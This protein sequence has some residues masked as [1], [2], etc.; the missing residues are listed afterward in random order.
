MVRQPNYLRM[1]G[2]EY[3]GDVAEIGESVNYRLPMRTQMKLDARW[4][5]DGVFLGKLDLSDEVIVGTPKG[6]ETVRSTR[7]KDD[8]H[9]W[10][11][12]AI[13]MFVGVPWN[14]RVLVAD[15]P[16]GTRRKYITRAL[17]AKY[18]ATDGC[19]GCAGDSQV[20]VPRCRLRFEKIFESEKSPGEPRAVAPREEEP[21]A[22]SGPAQQAPRGVPPP[23]AAAVGAG[24]ASGARPEPMAIEGQFGPHGDEVVTTPR[25]S[26]RGVVDVIGT[27][28]RRLREGADSSDEAMA[29]RAREV[30]SI[31]ELEVCEESEIEIEWDR[32]TQHGKIYLDMYTG[33]ALDPEL[34]QKGRETK[35]K[36]MLEFGVF[37]EI[38]ESEAVGKKIVNSDWKDSLKRD[39]LVRSRLVAQEV[40]KGDKREDVFAGAPPLSAMRYLLSRAASKG[41]ARS[42][43][44][45]DVSVAF[46]HAKMTEELIV[47]PPAIMR[48]PKKLWRL[49]KTVYGTQVAAKLWQ[50]LIRETTATGGWDPI[51]VLPCVC[52]NADADSMMIYHGDD[53]AVEGHDET[54][55]KCDAVLSNFEVKIAPR[56]GPTGVREAKFLGRTLTWCEEGFGYR[57]ATKHVDKLRKILSMD[58]CKPMDTP[59]S[60]ATGANVRDIEEK[61]SEHDAVIF[62]SAAG[63]LQFIVLDRPEILL[64]DKEIRQAVAA[65]DKLSMM[66]LRRV[67][68]YLTGE[69]E[70]YTAY[71]YQEQPKALDC[72]TDSDWGGAKVTRKSTSAGVIV[73]GSHWLEA[74]SAT[75]QTRALS[76]GEAELYAIVSGASRGLLLKH[77][78]SEVGDDLEL[79]ILSD[80]AAGRGMVQ[81]IGVGKAHHEKKFNIKKV[82]TDANLSDIG[83]KHLART[84]VLALL[85]KIGVFVQSSMGKASVLAC[86]FGHTEGKA[87]EV[88]E[89]GPILF[90]I[91]VALVVMIMSNTGVTVALLRGCGCLRRS[92]PERAVATPD[93]GSMELPAVISS[94]AVEASSSATPTTTTR[95]RSAASSAGVRRGVITQTPL[96]WK[97][98]WASP[99]MARL[100]EGA[101]G[102]FPCELD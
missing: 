10:N 26:P 59:G 74:W 89:E 85:G 23:A 79:N 73:A 42:I 44:T 99:R 39:G 51:W 75:Q 86:L 63:V 65:P 28:S 56:V 7:R 43:A 41:Q 35:V 36:R 45:Y 5:S 91:L 6:I 31:M 50:E 60:K 64:A 38:D 70:C 16:G 57:P 29:K 46:F 48:K 53:F 95:S 98:Y 93:S 94:S 88:A 49:L 12:E 102:A 21:T 78:A 11:A 37:E 100:P 25:T 14:P 20:H 67:V 3:K 68:R 30:M 84:R 80:S 66:R 62:H 1:K 9:R 34:V 13:R 69:R 24:S 87:A 47:R 96:T 17:I 22:P 32:L 82:S 90:T 101:D 77:L 2:K 76:S 97:S 61:L 55:D 92:A 15:A 4:E 33:E 54:L 40:V 83:T 58:G 27:P 71:H 52:Y 8:E 19:P 72:Y 18:G 81:R